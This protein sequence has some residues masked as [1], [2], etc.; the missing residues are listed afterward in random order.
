[1][2]RKKYSTIDCVGHGD[3][4]SVHSAFSA[5]NGEYFIGPWKLLNHSQN[6]LYRH[7]WFYLT[8]LEKWTEH[9][10]KICWKTEVSWL[11]LPLLVG[12]VKIF[13]SAEAIKK[14]IRKITLSSRRGTSVAKQ[15]N[16]ALDINFCTEGCKYWPT[17]IW[18]YGPC[19]IFLNIININL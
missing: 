3:L 1:M 19:K 7:V 12:Q 11:Y 9:I 6:Q 4:L 15:Q 14:R 8:W 13:R 18:V 5:T 2:T 16:L 10:T 17:N